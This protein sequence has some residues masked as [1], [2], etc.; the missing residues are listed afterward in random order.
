MKQTQAF[1]RPHHQIWNSVSIQYGASTRRLCA[2]TFHL[3]HSLALPA[4]NNIKAAVNFQSTFRALFNLLFTLNEELL[5][6][7]PFKDAHRGE[8]LFPRD[9][10]APELCRH[11]TAAPSEF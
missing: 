11:P 1:T 10:S 5:L 8:M 6:L 9:Q 3:P 7:L 4:R 2:S